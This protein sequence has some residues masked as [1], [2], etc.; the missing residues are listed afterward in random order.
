MQR[1][2]FHLQTL[3]V[4]SPDD[5]GVLLPDT[6]AVVNHAIA[7]ARTTMA[8]G[9]KGLDDGSWRGWAIIVPDEVGQTVLKVP[10]EMLEAAPTRRPA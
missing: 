4:R 1:Y 3:G 7:A 10:F 9:M 2:F 8:S 5:D 6:Q